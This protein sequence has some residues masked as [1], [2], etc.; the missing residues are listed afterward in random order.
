M[1]FFKTFIRGK[2]KWSAAQF[3]YILIVNLAYDK[4][5]LYKTLDY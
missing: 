3:Q 4:Q 1:F 2:S 5:K